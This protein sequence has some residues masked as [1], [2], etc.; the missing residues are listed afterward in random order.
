[1]ATVLLCANDPIL[2]EGLRQTLENAP[3]LDL[4]A[5]CPGLE[6]L[7]S[8][9]EFHQPDIL[10]LVVEDVTYAV[11]K[12]LR[13]AFCSS[14][15]VLWTDAIS[16]ELA[17]QSLSLGIR[18]LLRRNLPGDTLIRCLARVSEGE[19]WFDKALAQ[20][21]MTARSC[22]LTPREGQLVAQ[23]SQGLKNKEIATALNI[24]EGTVKVCIS[25]LFRKLG[26][27]D[28]LELALYGLRNHVARLGQ[29]PRPFLQE[30][31]PVGSKPGPQQ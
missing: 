30:R 21:M 18:G 4:V 16:T 29:P 17:S 7:R 12:G 3:G 15:I 20:S 24:T 28:R 22:S 19:L 1:M 27:K 25:R 14:R 10:L 8:Q 31:V 13:Q 26:V 23:L 5:C 6:D 2:A 11:L 9:L